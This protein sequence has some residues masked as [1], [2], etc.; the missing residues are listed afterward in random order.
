MRGLKELTYK[1]AEQLVLYSIGIHVKCL[2]IVV[3]DEKRIV[4][5]DSNGMTNYC[6]LYSPKAMKWLYD[7]AF[8]IQVILNDLVNEDK[9]TI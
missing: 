2:D 8:D 7:R 1:Q 5:L 6:E 9:Q 3:N 4:Y